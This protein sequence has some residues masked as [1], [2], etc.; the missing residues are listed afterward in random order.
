MGIE[1][2][3][4]SLGI[5]DWIII[6]TL[7]ILVFCLI[8]IRRLKKNILDEI[9]KR[10]VP[11]L[12]LELDIDER[13]I[14]IKNQSTMLAKDIKI[15]NINLTLVDYGFAMEFTLK[16]EIVEAVAAR[17]RLRLNFDV[18][19]ADDLCRPEESRR[20]IPHLVSAG[21]KA[22]ITYTN[23]ENLRFQSMLIKKAGKK[24][25]RLLRIESM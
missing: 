15:D 22:R 7:A 16:F 2:I 11:E 21:F 13:G 17:D 8:R 18:F 6:F 23:L 25:F 9:H 1:K 14:F 19:K 3:I 5:K 20:I 10:L 12:T 24:R 4:L